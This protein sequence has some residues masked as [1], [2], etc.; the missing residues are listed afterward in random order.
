MKLNAK[1]RLCALAAVALWSAGPATAQVAQP[2]YYPLTFSAEGTPVRTAACVAVAMRFTETE[3][4]W[5]PA[6]PAG[7]PAAADAALVKVLDA[8]RRKDRPALLD[9]SHRTHGRDPVRFEKQAGALFSQFQTLGNY[10][11]QYA[12]AFDDLTVYYLKFMVRGKPLLAPFIFELDS[13][14]AW[15]Y[16]PYRTTALPYELLQDWVRSPFGPGNGQPPELCTPAEVARLKL[17]IPLA[18]PAPAGAQRS[19]LLLN[20]EAPPASPP[21]V[22]AAKAFLAQQKAVAAKQFDAYAAG[23]TPA[24]RSRFEKWAASATPAERELLQTALSGMRPI[25]ALDLA[26]VTVLVLQGAERP[27]EAAYFLASGAGAPLMVN[28]A[29]VSTVDRIFKHHEGPVLSAVGQ[30]GLPLQAWA[31]QP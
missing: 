13:D 20:G 5:R 8:V 25:A 16:L 21:A 11:V 2:S 27:P 24:G 26:P 4:W 12:F 3:S 28:A 7:A 22:A 17:A 14:G 30:A 19:Q 29:H 15:R 31:R 1:F 9:A 10:T 6:A 23:L 18:G